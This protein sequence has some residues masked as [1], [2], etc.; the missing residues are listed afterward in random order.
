MPV[1]K[2]HHEYVRVWRSDAQRSCNRVRRRGGYTTH[3]SLRLV[4]VAVERGEF[5]HLELN[6]C[7]KALS[8]GVSHINSL[9]RSKRRVD[10]LSHPNEHCHLSSLQ[11]WVCLP[12]RSHFHLHRALHACLGR[13]W[14]WMNCLAIFL[15]WG[16]ILLMWLLLYDWLLFCCPL[17]SYLSIGACCYLLMHLWSIWRD[18]ASRL[19]HRIFPDHHS[20]LCSFV[21]H[22]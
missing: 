12:I 15:P 18:L 3:H 1:N 22:F 7:K 10:R 8:L 9:R 6:N 17:E 19:C 20:C 2:K 5:V 14:S 16:T 11:P 21:I 13:G 4:L